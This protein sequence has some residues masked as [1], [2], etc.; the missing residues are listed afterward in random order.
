MWGME[1]SRSILVINRTFPPSFGATGR[2]ACDLA[3]HLR[4][5]GHKVTILT[6]AQ[7]AKTDS[8]KNLDV[9]RIAANQKPNSIFNYLKILWNMY[10]A[11]KKIPD[12]D[13]VISMTDPP[14]QSIIGEKIARR[15]SAKH[16]HWAMDLYPDLL[17]VLETHIRPFIFNIIKSKM[18]GTYK[19][20]D[21]IVTISKCMARYL[22]HHSVPRANMHII[23]N[24]PDKYLREDNDEPAQ[25]L[26]D[27]KKFR[28][29]Y[30]GTI[31]LAHEFDTVLK[32]AKYLQKHAPNIE[33]IFTNRGGGKNLLAEKIKKHGLRNIQL[34]SPQPSKKLSA[35]MAS[36]DLH[37]ITMKDNAVGKLF[38]SKFYSAIAA[39]R[40]SLFIGPNTC[41]LH[42]KITSNALGVSVRN[43]DAKS[44]TQGI[45][46]YYDDGD[47]WFNHCANAKKMMANHNPLNEWTKLINAL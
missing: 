3:L 32:S 5:R 46:K 18:Y 29:L 34:I 31:G 39:G 41:D 27:D 6:T 30:A 20:A 43:G 23:E 26:L 21:A 19:N 25:S 11:S 16:I 4:H 38:P 35:L 22:T 17:P 13:I 44:F 10:H 33:F 47:T 42:N 14:L 2:M 8:A 37:L 24:W 12:H 28:I 15:M 40:P 9:I 1:K 45:L 36:G 7:H